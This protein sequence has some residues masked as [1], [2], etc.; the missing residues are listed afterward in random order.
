MLAPAVHNDRHAPVPCN[1]KSRGFLKTYLGR[2]SASTQVSALHRANR[3]ANE[4][5]SASG[6]PR[7]TV[8]MPVQ[9]HR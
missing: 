9:P 2:N 5:S 4:K 1:G 7:L 8:S 3:R 6:N